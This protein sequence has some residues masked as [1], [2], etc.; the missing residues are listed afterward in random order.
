M[1]KVIDAEGNFIQ[2]VK[3]LSMPCWNRALSHIYDHSFP[4]RFKAPNRMKRRC[5]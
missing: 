4:L 5:P 1:V 3:F 2:K